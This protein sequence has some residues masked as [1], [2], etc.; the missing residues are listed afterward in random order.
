MKRRRR[1]RVSGISVAKRGQRIG[2]LDDPTKGK[3]GEPRENG[4]APRVRVPS[5]TVRSSGNWKNTMNL[6][7]T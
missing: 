5:A 3:E 2:A 1:R 4:G 6:N 7:L